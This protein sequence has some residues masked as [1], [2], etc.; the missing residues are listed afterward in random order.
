LKF[1]HVIIATVSLVLVGL[2]LDAFLMVAFD[3]LNSNSTSDIAAIIAFLVASLIVGYVFALRIQEG[4][5]IKA[6]G[7]I[8]VLSAFALLVFNSVWI[9]NPFASPLFQDSLNNMLNRTT[10]QWTH[11]DLNAY[12]ALL[13]SLVVIIASVINFVGLYAGS[14]LRKPSAKTK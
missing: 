5:R 7:V 12:T 13:V 3:S 11:Y 10:S 2:I 1:S 6:I 14:V 4:S 9:A 8:V